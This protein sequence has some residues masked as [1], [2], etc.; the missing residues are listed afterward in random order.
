MD[1]N[2][3]KMDQNRLIIDQIEPQILIL[4]KMIKSNGKMDQKMSKIIK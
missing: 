4:D 1:Q 2:R 3:L